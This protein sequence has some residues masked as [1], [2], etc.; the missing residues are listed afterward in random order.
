MDYILPIASQTTLG[1]IK[2]GAGLTILDNG[3][4]NVT[5]NPV[6]DGSYQ[7]IIVSSN[8]TIYTIAS[9]V[10][11]NAKLYQMPAGTIKA[12]IT[13]APAQPADVTL[14]QLTSNL[15]VFTG[16]SGSGGVKGL[17]PAP[18]AG[19]AAANKYLKAN[20]QWATISGGTTAVWGNITGTLSNQTDLNNALLALV[21]YTGATADVDLGNFSANAKSF[22]VKGTA[23]QGHIGMKW[24]SAD[25]TAGGNESS[26]WA[27]NL[28]NINWKIDGHYKVGFISSGNTANRSYTLPNASGTFALTSQL[29]NFGNFGAITPLLYD[30]TG[31]FSIQQAD[32]THDGYLSQ[33]DWSTFNNKAAGTAVYSA[34]SGPLPE[35][36][37][38]AD[39]VYKLDST[40][41]GF[42]ITTNNV[43]LNVQR[44]TVTLIKTDK[45]ANQ[46]KFY[47]P[48]GSK[49]NGGV[50]N[51]AIVLAAPNDTATIYFDGFGG[52]DISYTLQHFPVKIQLSAQGSF[53]VPA[54]YMIKNLVAR[55]TTGTAT[56]LKFGTTLGGTD[57]IASL[58]LASTAPVYAT[59]TQLLKRVFSDITGSPQTIYIDDT[60]SWPIGAVVDLSIE[61]E[62]II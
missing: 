10:V 22:H 46:I 44:R 37:I 19:D 55:E 53:V 34:S 26:L 1:G 49:F 21:P 25:A 16:D 51:G 33:S 43:L 58:S 54:G 4:V 32:A 24:Q 35:S 28:G 60:T 42:D 50:T 12:N 27:D 47:P 59:D 36:A 48:S 2:I 20:G 56:T 13:G 9:N 5:N 6:A 18:A 62:Q 57:V 23:G 38:I 29:L 14:S 30:G 17:V 3:T 40:G 52:S 45:T 61:L 31:G 8:G 41:G 39:K 15:S 11:T 7:D